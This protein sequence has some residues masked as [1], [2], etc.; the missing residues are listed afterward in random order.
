[1]TRQLPSTKKFLTVIT[2][3]AKFIAIIFHPHDCIDFNLCLYDAMKSG[4]LFMTEIFHIFEGCKLC[5]EKFNQR[6]KTFMGCT[7][8]TSFL[9]CMELIILSAVSAM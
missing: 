5:R 8:V 1:M 2:L 9:K 4:A 7:E 3:P 6:S